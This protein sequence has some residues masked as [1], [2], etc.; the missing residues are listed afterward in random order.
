MGNFNTVKSIKISKLRD[1]INK[2]ELMKVKIVERTGGS[3]LYNSF[4]ALDP[5]KDYDGEDLVE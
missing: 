2:I 3:F 4:E 1:M 5:S